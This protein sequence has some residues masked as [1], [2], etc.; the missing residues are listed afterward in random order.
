M[1]YFVHGPDRLLA[2]Q[3]VHAIATEADPDGANTS[4]FDGR[5]TPLERVIAAVGAASFFGS[6]RVVIVTDLLGKAPRESDT[7]E[8]DE[9][10]DARP[11]RGTSPIDPL[12]AAVPDENVLILHEPGL[13]APP[14]A[15][16][17]AAARVTIVAG[18]PPRGRELL[19][20]IETAARAADSRIDRRTA[21]LLAETLYPQTWDRKPAIPRYDRPPDLAHLTAEIEKLALA[22]HPGPIAAEHIGSLVASGPDQRLFRFV[23]AALDG[24]LRQAVAELDRLTAAGE[25]PAMLLA[26]VLGQTEL[27]AVAA[28]AGGRDAAAVSRDLGT[29]GAGRMSAVMSSLRGRR[30]VKALAAVAKGTRADR[31]LKTGRVRQPAGALHELV[32][33]LA[34]EERK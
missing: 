13:S 6:A 20:W 31:R 15:L 2:R 30:G 22:A 24:D 11:T 5:D 28:A 33:D 29:V 32:L 27:A 19:G 7:G 17:A 26:Q 4:W 16:K 23:D 8:A 21:Q 9:S 14:A 3:A 18:E 10:V 12:L 34:F 1:I 25:E